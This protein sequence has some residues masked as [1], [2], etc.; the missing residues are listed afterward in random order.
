MKWCHPIL[1]GI[2]T[3]F[4]RNFHFSALFLHPLFETTA[5]E[6]LLQ[7][8]Q[9]QG[10]DLS[11]TSRQVFQQLLQTFARLNPPSVLTFCFLCFSSMSFPVC[12]V[13]ASLH[14]I[15]RPNLDF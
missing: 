8:L 11:F 14:S 2:N 15:E 10:I 13:F 4:S 12:L 6:G 9:P 1:L 5:K 7:G 3:F